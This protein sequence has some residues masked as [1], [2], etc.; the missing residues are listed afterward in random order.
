MVEQ[1]RV[2]LFQLSVLAWPVYW[3]VELAFHIATFNPIAI[4]SKRAPTS[5]REH[6]ET[7]SAIWSKVEEVEAKL[8][9]VQ[10]TQHRLA[11]LH[12]Y[13]VSFIRRKAISGKRERERER[14]RRRE[15]EGEGRQR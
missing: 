8:A 13:E 14:E 3:L 4:D 12:F 11:H 6:E 15:R 9:V 5:E 7:R 2:L 10:H 1:V